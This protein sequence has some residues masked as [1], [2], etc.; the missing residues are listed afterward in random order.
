MTSEDYKASMKPVIDA[1]HGQI[2]I[3]LEYGKSLNISAED[4]ATLQKH[5][6]G[7]AICPA[8]YWFEDTPEVRRIL[9]VDE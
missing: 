9:K 5:L 7:Q 4:E 6:K 8:L 2:K 3:T 1:R